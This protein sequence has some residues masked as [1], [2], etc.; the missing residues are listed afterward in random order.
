MHTHPTPSAPHPG[1]H[2][3]VAAAV[4][5]GP[6]DLAAFDAALRATGCAN[7]NL[8]RL[9]SV[10]PPAST[11]TVHDGPLIPGGTWGDRLHVVYAAEYAHRHGE[12]AWAGIGWTQA[13]EVG[14][15]LFVEHEGRSRR[16]VSDLIDESL[17]DMLVGRGLDWT[18]RERHL[19]G[20]DDAAGVHTCALVIA[21]YTTAGWE[22][23]GAS[24]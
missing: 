4:G 14:A 19:V 10:I 11:V 18:H 24:R 12:A 2:I 1:L 7:Y 8:V 6:N 16:D 22:P 20:V 9:S 13:D 17:D 5:R 15:G 21:T 23:Q 3:S